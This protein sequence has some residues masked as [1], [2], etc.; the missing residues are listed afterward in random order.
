MIIYVQLGFNQI[1]SLREK[2]IFIFTL[3]VLLDF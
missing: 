3:R 2:K 1:S